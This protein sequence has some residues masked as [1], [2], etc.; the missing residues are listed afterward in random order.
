MTECL[1]AIID[2]GF[3]ELHLYHTQMV[4]NTN[5]TKNVAIS[6][7]LDFTLEETLRQ[8]HKRNGR[9]TGTYIFELLKN[10]WSK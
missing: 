7:R 8:N 2:Y 10:E 1:K 9:L 5:N 4:C 3:Y 6:K